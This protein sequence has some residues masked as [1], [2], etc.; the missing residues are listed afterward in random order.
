MKECPRCHRICLEEEGVLNSISHVGNHVQ[1]C[2]KC[3]E[4]Q[5]N[6]GMNYTTDIVEV[7][8]EERFRRELGL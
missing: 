1:I 3:G 8:M 6:V 2:S 5:G 7:H 4:E